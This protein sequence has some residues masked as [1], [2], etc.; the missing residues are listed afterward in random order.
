MSSKLARESSRSKEFWL[1]H[2]QRWS[3]SGLSKADYCRQN[4]LSAGNFYNWFSKESCRIEPFQRSTSTT[5]LNLLPVTLTDS[6]PKA[7]TVTLESNG[8]TFKFPANLPTDEID[9]W[10]SVI[11]R[12]RA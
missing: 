7:S 5:A 11:E 9:R 12:Q 1:S 3:S 6:A 2:I 8:L 10:L 4:N